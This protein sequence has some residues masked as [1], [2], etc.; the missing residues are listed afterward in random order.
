MNSIHQFNITLGLAI[1]F[2]FNVTAE[3]LPPAMPDLKNEVER[4]KEMKPSQLAEEQKTMYE[5]MKK[6][7]PEQ[8]ADKRNDMLD[9]LDH[10][11]DAERRALNDKKVSEAEKIFAS[12]HAE[13][14]EDVQSE[15]PELNAEILKQSDAAALGKLQVDPMQSAIDQVS[16][17]PKAN[18]EL[19]QKPIKHVHKK[20]ASVNKAS[21]AKK[22]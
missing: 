21:K 9:E 11:S 4:L 12:E 16:V 10:M 8:R 18:K 13:H 15:S 14:S 19:L 5:A 22:K 6:M 3:E 2:I 7:T 1:F 20:P 17:S